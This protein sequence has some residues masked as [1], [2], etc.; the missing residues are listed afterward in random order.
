[1]VLRD[2]RHISLSGLTSTRV[3]QA[4]SRKKVQRLLDALNQELA[5][6]TTNSTTGVAT[7]PDELSPGT[8]VSHPAL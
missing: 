4:H 7:P 1:V 6:H 3:L 8:T 5:A 2:G